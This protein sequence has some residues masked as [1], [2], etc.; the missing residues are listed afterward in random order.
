MIQGDCAS[1]GGNAAVFICE[2]SERLHSFILLPSIIICFYAASIPT[3]CSVPDALPES[4]GPWHINKAVLPVAFGTAADC[5]IALQKEC[6]AE[7]VVCVGQ[8]AGRSAVTP[9]LVA[10]NLQYASIPDNAGRSPRDVPAVP[11]AREAYFSTLPVRAMADAIRAD[12]IPAALS[13]SAGLYVCND[14]YYR[15]LHHYANTGV[16]VAF[17]HVPSASG[18]PSME[19]ATAARALCLAI[20]QIPGERP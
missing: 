20:A 3:V 10:L 6:G 9:E 12:G 8:A 16:R 19:P 13:Q 2:R 7:V 4:I 17:L 1:F 11:G 18:T 5:A 15:L 14:L